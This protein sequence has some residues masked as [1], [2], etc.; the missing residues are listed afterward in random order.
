MHLSGS[1]GWDYYARQQTA[2]THQ[3]LRGSAQR[4]I[5]TAVDIDPPPE[6]ICEYRV[7]RPLLRTEQGP[8]LK[9]QL[10]APQLAQSDYNVYVRAAAPTRPLVQWSP[11]AGEKNELEF[12]G[13]DDS[14]ALLPQFEAHSR[15]VDTGAGA[16]LRSLELKNYR[17]LGVAADA[18]PLP[19]EV[20]K[21]LGWPARGSYVP[22]AYQD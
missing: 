20:A 1:A 7:P 10:T 15:V 14:R 18:S 6:R 3:L 22:G 16:Q 2:A 17:P 9:G 4:L 5:V 12:A 11:V 8:K 21:L 19:A 13:L